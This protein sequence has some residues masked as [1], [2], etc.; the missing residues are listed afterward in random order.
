MSIGNNKPSGYVGNTFVKDIEDTSKDKLFLS[1]VLKN[2][3]FPAV[4]ATVKE[5]HIDIVRA[6]SLIYPA[7]ILIDVIPGVSVRMTPKDYVQIF[8]GNLDAHVDYFT[9][10]QG[11]YNFEE[12]F[13]QAKYF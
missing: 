12:V 4:Y 2:A 13:T 8:G 9:A 10:A 7:L 6:L 5:E 1:V 3:I 11:T